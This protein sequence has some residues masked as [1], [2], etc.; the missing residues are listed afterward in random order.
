MFIGYLVLG[1]RMFENGMK[2]RD[3]RKIIK[4]IDFSRKAWETLGVVDHDGN[5]TNTDKVRKA[6]KQY[7]E[8]IEI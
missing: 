4:S 6:I 5:L 3:I 2:A 8:E 1:R 7:F